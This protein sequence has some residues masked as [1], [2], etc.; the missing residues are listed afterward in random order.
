MKTVA[1][2]VIL[3]CFAVFGLFLD[4]ASCEAVDTGAEKAYSKSDATNEQVVS[5]RIIDGD[6]LIVFIGG[7]EYRCRLIGVDTPEMSTDFGAT[8]KAFTEAEIG[9]EGTE[10]VLQFDVGRTDKYGRTLAYVWTKYD[11]DDG[12]AA[13][14]PYRTMLNHKLVLQGYARLMTVPPN[15]AYEDKFGQA[16]QVAL[17]SGTG[18]WENYEEL[19]AD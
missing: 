6:T 17:E 7:D 8:A 5:D 14:E 13:G 19:F 3:C 16:E 4:L 15:V 11:Y 9:G 1:G 2:I 18:I 12:L 10:L